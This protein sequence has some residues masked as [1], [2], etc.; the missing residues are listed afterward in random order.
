MK[1]YIF[2]LLF[3]TKLFAQKHDNVWVLGYGCSP[4]DTVD[5]NV[6]LTF[7]DSTPASEKFHTSAWMSIT[8]S[9]IC[10]ERGELQFY[11][12]GQHIYNKS[13]QYMANENGFNP[14]DWTNNNPN[15]GMHITQAVQIL[16]CPQDT[17]LYYVFHSSGMIINPDL[18][19]DKFYYSLID[20]R[21]DSGRG[22]VIDKNHLLIDDL[23][24][25]G[26]VNACKHANGIDWWIMIPEY[27][28]GCF[29]RFLLTQNGIQSYPKQCDGPNHPDP[30]SSFSLF[31]PDGKTYIKLGT[32][33][34]KLLFYHFDRCKGEFTHYLTTTLPSV[35]GM[36]AFSPNSRFL[37]HCNANEI[38]QYD[39]QATNIITSKQ[40]VAIW[41]GFSSPTPCNFY[42]PLLA[43]DNRIYITTTNNSK[44]LSYINQPDSLGIACDVQQHGL[45]LT[46]V[47]STSP[48]NYPHFRLGA[49]T[50]ACYGLW[51]E[52]EEGIGKEVSIYPNPT[53]DKLTFEFEDKYDVLIIYNTLGQEIK[54]YF[55]P[56]GNKFTIEVSSWQEGTYHYQLLSKA[57]HHH[58]KFV[59][60]K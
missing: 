14:G 2:L 22:A 7:N 42:Y 52:K 40:V 26:N 48:P 58:G 20:M 18:C 5:C 34:G 21:Q 23:L 3:I 10:N 53:K 56:E 13:Y 60:I 29:Y 43:A 4:T 47:G 33:T 45:L 54:K 15:D 12:N 49:D 37:Y 51:I 38:Y 41:D 55:L 28:T 25:L 9:S 11:S 1:K 31:S 6:I 50:T 44:Y 36:M 32:L 27:G 19:P 59:I 8:N 17:N 30:R 35:L 46:G 39:M 57:S 16:P 24:P